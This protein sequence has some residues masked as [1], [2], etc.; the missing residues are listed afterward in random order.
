[1]TTF[2]AIARHGGRWLPVIGTSA[3]VGTAS[4]L[5]LPTVLGKAVDA[6]VTG[7]SGGTWL[8]AAGLLIA[9]GI[10]SDL[11]DSFA[12]VA[13]VASTTA[14]L[15]ERLITHLLAVGPNRRFDTGDLV[16]R[17]SGNAVDAAQAGPAVV[18]VWM[19]VLPPA[20]SLVLLVV[21]DPWLAAAFLAGVGLVAL[22][23][24]AFTRRTAQVIT[25]Y[26]QVQGRIAARL[27]E[28]L[29]GARTIAAAGTTR[30][31]KRRVL[32]ELPALHDQGMAS[33]RVLSRSVAQAGV[34]GPLVTVAVLAAGGMA[35]LDGR[36]TP[37]E[38]FAAVQYAV[39]GAGLGGMT[40]VFGRLARARAGAGRAAE[41]LGTAAIG[42]GHLRLAEGEGRVEFRHV[43]V[44]RGEREILADVSLTL[45]GGKAVAVVGRSGAGKST[46]AAVAARLEEPASGDVLLDDVPMKYL[47]RDELRRAVGCAFERPVLVGGTVA[48][49]VGMG[50]DLDLV[51]SA[52]EATHAHEFVSRLPLGYNTPLAQAPMSGGEAQ[53]LGLARA[54]NAERLLVLDDATSSLDMVTEMQIGRTLTADHGHRTRLIVTH[55]VATAANADLVVWLESGRVRATGTHADLWRDPAYRDVFG[56]AE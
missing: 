54:W 12:G 2:G 7:G 4:T 19:A 49:A 18:T 45:P 48:D 37:G 50:R 24:R 15:R 43:T 32:G 41:V 46:L 11:V 39:L 23:L 20:G 47:T 8:V 6:I 33:W 25:S 10:A 51:R 52:A 36:I 16:T 38:L 56:A 42:Y 5:A 22:V 1:M 55:R 27:A 34:V 14:W 31:E 35:L 53:R 3:L 26:Q 29:A 9:V 44:H 17:V 30:D 28:S 40:S 21:I 13:C